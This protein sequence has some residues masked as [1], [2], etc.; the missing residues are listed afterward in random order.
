MTAI[1]CEIIQKNYYRTNMHTH[2]MIKQELQNI[3]NCGFWVRVPYGFYVLLLQVF[4]K[5]ENI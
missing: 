1:F 3:Y 2:I 5:T 4:C